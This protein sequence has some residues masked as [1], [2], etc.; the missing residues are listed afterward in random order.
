[1]HGNIPMKL[2]HTLIYVNKKGIL[3][4][5]GVQAYMPSYL[6]CGD[7]EDPGLRIGLKKFVRPISINKLGM[8][9]HICNLSHEGGIG[10]RD[11]DLRLAFRQNSHE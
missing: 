10:Y 2:L 1:M 4:R 8:V 3:A 9:V 6:G 5:Y 7:W 11:H